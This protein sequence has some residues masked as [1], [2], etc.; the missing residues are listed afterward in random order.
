MKAG[1]VNSRGAGNS[2]FSAVVGIL[3]QQLRAG[4]LPQG[5]KSTDISVQHGVVWYKIKLLHL[6]PFIELNA[7]VFVTTISIATM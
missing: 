5:K 3:H 7:T 6:Y 1:V 4:Y 2:P